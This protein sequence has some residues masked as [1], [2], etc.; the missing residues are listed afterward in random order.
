MAANNALTKESEEFKRE[1]LEYIAQICG[2][3]FRECSSQEKYDALVNMVRD[4]CSGLRSE[5]VRRW[6]DQK[7]KVV[8]Y[9]SLEFLIGRLL[10]NYLIQIG[11][12]DMVAEVFHELGTELTE[13]LECERDPGLGNGGLGRL[14]ACF[15][16]STAA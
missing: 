3:P 9:F 4:S 13:I 10:E 2:K 15:L 7:R 11:I 16:E 5:T 14:A 1:Y 12:R 8:Y 6:N